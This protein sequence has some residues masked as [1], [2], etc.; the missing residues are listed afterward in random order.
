MR[1]LVLGSDGMLGHILTNYLQKN[2]DFQI[3]NLSKKNINNNQNHFICDINHK[4]S[5]LKICDKIRPDLIINCIGVLIKKSKSS[6]KDA[7]YINAYFPN[8]LDEISKKNEFK[9]IHIST[10]CVFSGKTGN[11]SETSIKDSYDIYGLTKS[12]GEINSSNHLTIRTSII[13]PELKKNG[14]GLFNWFINQSGKTKGYTNAIWSGVTTLELS[15]AILFSIL[16]D[17]TGIW[18]LSSE[19][20]IS[21][22]DLLSKIKNQFNLHKIKLIKDDNLIINKSLI[23]NRKISYIVPSYDGMINELFNYVSDNKNIYDIDL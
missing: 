1:V 23:S 5:F 9:L 14:E 19:Q 6:S 12:L 11:Y 10:D 18:N 21:K 13:G 22:Y 7:I 4:E 3:F 20:P 8:F 15:K 17:I 2:S 16:N